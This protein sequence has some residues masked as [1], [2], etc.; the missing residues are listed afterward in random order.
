MT[1]AR[2]R[3]A[4][5]AMIVAMIGPL[6]VAAATSSRA[7]RVTKADVASARSRLGTL[8][9]QLEVVVE[10]YDGAR[11]LLQQTQQKLDS[12][13][14]QMQNAQAT[15]AAARAQL[16]QRAAEAYTGMGSSSTRS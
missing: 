10:Q 1:K 14:A 6:T 3:L 15:S 5:S 4:A 8:N 7:T 13:R 12:A 11:V 2:R 16:G 9:R